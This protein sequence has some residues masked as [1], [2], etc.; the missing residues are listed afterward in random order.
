MGYQASSVHDKSSEKMALKST[1]E[2]SKNAYYT[3]YLDC[4]DELL[5]RKHPELGV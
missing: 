2:A 4:L 1:E 3:H 5:S